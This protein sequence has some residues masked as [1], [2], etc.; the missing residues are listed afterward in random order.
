VEA[1]LTVL[2]SPRFQTLCRRM[3]VV[4]LVA[5]FSS[6]ASAGSYHDSTH[7][8]KLFATPAK[9]RALLEGWVE[10]KPDQARIEVIGQS[11]KSRPPFKPDTPTCDILALHVTDSTVPESEKQVV[12]IVGMRVVFSVAP[13]LVLHSARWLLGSDPLAIE[14]R[15]RQHVI[16]V[17]S[18]R[19]YYQ[20]IG[21]MVSETLYDH[22]NWDGVRDP[23][24][25]I[26][27]ASIQKLLDTWKPEVFVDLSS[28]VVHREAMVMEAIG[29]RAR[30][31]L[32][33]CYVPEIPSR[34]RSAAARGG[35]QVHSMHPHFGHGL[36][37]SPIPLPGAN[38]HYYL[39]SRKVLPTDYAYRQHHTLGLPVIASFRESLLLMMQ[40]LF[41]IGNATWAGERSTG[42]PT[43]VVGGAGPVM[44]A[45][46]GKNAAEQ[47]ASRCE[48]WQK[49]AQIV[50]NYAIDPHPD[51][52]VAVV[53][54]EP[55]EANTWFAAGPRSHP[56]TSAVAVFDILE[57][58]ETSGRF[59]PGT[60]DPVRG[61]LA[62]H[63]RGSRYTFRPHGSP[64]TTAAT[65]VENGLNLRCLFPYRHPEVRDVR[66]DGRLLTPSPTDGYQIIRGPGTIVEIAIPPDQVQNVHV[67][68]VELEGDR[69]FEEQT[70]GPFL[71][72]P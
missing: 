44:V 8:P 24:T 2:C 19:P 43:R 33:S 50:V 18:A 23:A 15:R 60:L 58:L 71:E 4:F 66:L 25:N 13:S 56:G 26:E 36:V 69:P 17:P 64:R 53:M 52:L 5:A 32:S 34:L 38:A 14:T 48:L 59:E 27:S 12:V 11:W 46:W 29:L 3:G 68:S 22:W 62:R 67:I 31:A 30:S 63:W 9:M 7:E 72:L 70:E 57:N 28:R 55:G 39:G 20:I 65:P 42:Y 21:G 54:T 16:F 51:A 6:I 61:V 10:R 35:Y 47:R 1:L 41:R 45:A 37:P 49:K 40:E